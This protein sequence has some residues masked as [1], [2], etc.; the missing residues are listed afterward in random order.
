M[1]VMRYGHY[2]AVKGNREEASAKKKK[3]I[4]KNVEK[5]D[6]GLKKKQETCWKSNNK[7]KL[8]WSRDS[9]EI[10]MSFCVTA[11]NKPGAEA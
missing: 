3:N 9:A 5:R 1:T 6:T 2:E 10:H 7:Q 11:T 8:T 4:I